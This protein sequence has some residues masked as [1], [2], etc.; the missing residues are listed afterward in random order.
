MITKIVVDEKI[1]KIF[2]WGN[3]TLEKKFNAC[4][5]PRQYFNFYIQKCMVQKFKNET[6]KICLFF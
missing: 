5:S 1:K 4:T 2:F 3:V 6:P